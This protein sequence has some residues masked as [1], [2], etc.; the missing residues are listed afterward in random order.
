VSQALQIGRYEVIHKLREGG[1]GA[2]FLARDPARPGACGLAVIKRTRAGRA[3]DEQFAAMFRNEIRINALLD[4]PNVPRFIE[5]GEHEGAPY[6]VLEYIHGADLKEVLGAAWERPGC[7]LDAEL[8]AYIGVGVAAALDHAHRLCDQQ[9]N[10]LNV[11]HR[12]ITPHNIRLGHDGAVKVL[13]FGVAKAANQSFVT[14]AGVTKG[15]FPYMSPEQVVGDTVDAQ[16][17]I[18]AL[19][20]V[21][22]ETLTRRS[23]FAHEDAAIT[24]SAI[25]SARIPLPSELTGAAVPARLEAIVMRALERDRARRYAGADEL[26]AELEALLRELAGA[27]PPEQRLARLITELFGDGEARLAAVLQPDDAGSDESGAGSTI[28][29]AGALDSG[30]DSDFDDSDAYDPEASTVKG[31]PDFTSQLLTPRSR[32]KG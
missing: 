23:L 28:I 27:A 22:H 15:K 12:D 7:G 3:G 31:R 20:I 29:E 13:D 25:Q 30:P 11:V 4:S 18:F 5:A 2:V 32:N 1:M 9:L 24:I 21:M 17:D 16:T 26:L 8:A 19:G 10:P 6:L 14:A